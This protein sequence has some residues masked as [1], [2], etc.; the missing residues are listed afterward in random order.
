MA[1]Q[2]QDSFSEYVKGVIGL[3]P[4]GLSPHLVVAVFPSLLAKA[5]ALIVVGWQE[6]LTYL[7]PACTRKSSKPVSFLIFLKLST[8][9]VLILHKA[10]LARCAKIGSNVGMFLSNT[11]NPQ[12]VGSNIG[13]AI[14]GAER[15]EGERDTF[16]A[17]VEKGYDVAKR[18]N[19]NYVDFEDNVNPIAKAGIG[20][21]LDIVADPITWAYCRYYWW[22]KVAARGGAAALP[23]PLKRVT[24]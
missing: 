14:T 7:A 17:V 5:R 16:E 18:N 15:P 19:P 23:L 13:K 20:L 9:P 12:T 4:Q 11:W 2:P 6:L 8:M 22:A 3:I 10:I 1:E 21:T 24:R